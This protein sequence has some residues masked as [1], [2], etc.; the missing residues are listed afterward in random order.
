MLIEFEESAVCLDVQ[1]DE[2]V[3]VWRKVQGHSHS[4]VA[5]ALTLTVKWEIMK[6][7]FARSG[8]ITQ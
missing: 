4:A 5:H 6:A 7:I 2:G 8:V 3:Q 1:D